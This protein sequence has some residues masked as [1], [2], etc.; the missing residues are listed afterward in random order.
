MCVEHHLRILW[1]SINRLGFAVQDW[2]EIPFEEW[3][4][5][6]EG[7]TGDL[8]SVWFNDIKSKSKRRCIRWFIS[9]LFKN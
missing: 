6:E 8:K 3:S 2:M 7:K 5:L 4:H 9:L 1:Y